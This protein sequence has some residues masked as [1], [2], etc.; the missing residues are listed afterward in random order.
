MRPMQKR[1]ADTQVYANEESSPPNT[2]TIGRNGAKPMTYKAN[3]PLPQEIKQVRMKSHF[4]DGEVLTTQT[5]S[6][7]NKAFVLQG[8]GGYYFEGRQQHTVQDG[9]SELPSP[10]SGVVGRE[11]SSKMGLPSMQG[12]DRIQDYGKAARPSGHLRTRGTSLTTIRRQVKIQRY[13]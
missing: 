11:R 10:D 13:N 7:K 4:C 9:M 12:N 8:Q 5:K 6:D 1:N 2:A 3:A